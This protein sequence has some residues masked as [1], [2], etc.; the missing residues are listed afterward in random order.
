VLRCAQALQYVHEKDLV[1]RDI[2]PDNILLGRRGEVKIVDLGMVKQLDDDMSLTQTGHAVGTPWY[3][4]LEQAKNA[5]NTDCRCDIYALGCVFYAC[6]TGRPPFTGRSIVDVIQAKEV[7][8]FPPAR[9][10]N[11]QVPERVDLIIA[12]MMA[13]DPK[14][15]YQSC[16]PL[17]ADLE[18]LELAHDV[19]TFLA[20]LPQP[21]GKPPAVSQDAARPRASAQTPIPLMPAPGAGVPRS[22]AGKQ[23]FRSRKHYEKLVLEP[24]L[25]ERH[26]SQPVKTLRYWSGSFTRVAVV[27]AL[28]GALWLG[29]SYL[30]TSLQTL[31]R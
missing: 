29:A 1:H 15:R 13:R 9:H 17:I 8:T 19:L 26:K 21:A 3:M 7:G 23:T 5:K 10:F 22:G 18:G 28:L 30:V 25:P 11:R 12:K 20:S 24:V 31:F 27:L 16:S 14:Y 6:L 4:P 2:K